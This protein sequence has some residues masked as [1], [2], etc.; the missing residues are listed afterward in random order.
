MSLFGGA[1]ASARSQLCDEKWNPNLLL[2][3][4]Q[5]D[6][7]IPFHT[8]FKIAGSVPLRYGIQASFSFQ[9]LRHRPRVPAGRLD[10]L[11]I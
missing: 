4:N 8:Q 2:Y 11:L 9:S 6:S 3:C 7:G 5:L 10:P 1:P